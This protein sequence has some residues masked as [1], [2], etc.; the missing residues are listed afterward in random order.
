MPNCDSARWESSPRMVEAHRNIFAHEVQ[1]MS[2]EL[3]PAYQRDITTF[4]DILDF[5]RDVKSLSNRI[6]LLLPIEAVLRH[7]ANCKRNIDHARS[8]GSGR[9]DA[10]MT[11]FSD[12]VVLS[13]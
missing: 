12:C 10:R 6:Q 13:Y 8:K 5:T 9:H 4:I 7:I 2:T 11:S 3:P 1:G